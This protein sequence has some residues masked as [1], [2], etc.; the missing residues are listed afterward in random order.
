M[1]CQLHH[2]PLY[3]EDSSLLAVSRSHRCSAST[4]LSSSESR[5]RSAVAARSM[6][7]R[8]RSITSSTSCCEL[9]RCC[10]LIARHVF[11]YRSSSSFRVAVRSASRD[12]HCAKD[13]RR[14][15][16]LW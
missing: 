1:V 6:V 9:P 7:C 8:V 16:P 15:S 12:F 11:L 4:F 5:E 3:E 13:C 10:V 2:F 14:A